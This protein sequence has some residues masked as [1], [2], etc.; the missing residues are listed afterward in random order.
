MTSVD[1]KKPEILNV[2]REV[3]KKELGENISDEEILEKCLQFSA[4]HLD[5]LL[6]EDN[7]S[8]KYLD[9]LLNTEAVKK[10]SIFDFM[11]GILE[12]EQEMIIKSGKTIKEVIHESWK[13]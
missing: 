7:N 6:S 4:D 13:Y 8:S 10:N 2:L 9:N 12:D 5:Q 1:I 11:S 3:F